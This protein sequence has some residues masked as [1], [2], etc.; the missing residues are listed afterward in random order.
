LRLVIACAAAA[1][2]AALAWPSVA[3]ASD[4]DLF[5]WGPRSPAMGG[6]GAASSHGADAAYTNPAL[7]AC[8]TTL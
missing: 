4:E 7:L 1:A 2:V 3:R 5:G 8:T 6:T